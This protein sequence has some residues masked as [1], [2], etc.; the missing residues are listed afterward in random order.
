MKQGFTNYIGKL[1]KGKPHLHEQKQFLLNHER[2]KIAEENVQKEC[3]AASLRWGAR[4]NKKKLD[5]LIEAG[6]SIFCDCAIAAKIRQ[7]T[8]DAELKR[9]ESKA[10]ELADT[11]AMVDEMEREAMST[12]IHKPGADVPNAEEAC[13]RDDHQL[14][15]CAEHG[16][17]LQP[18]GRDSN[19]AGINPETV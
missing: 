9:L 11:Q 17:A 1:L 10:G 5:Q 19:L 7:L 16:S 4:F 15:G 18:D 12:A 3:N 8:T 2:R 14:A 13:K 6:A